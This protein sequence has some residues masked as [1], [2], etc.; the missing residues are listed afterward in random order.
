MYDKYHAVL[1]RIPY[2][3]VQ[4]LE[5]WRILRLASPG[6]IRNHPEASV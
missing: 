5:D 4:P 3:C 1:F 6:L 2:D